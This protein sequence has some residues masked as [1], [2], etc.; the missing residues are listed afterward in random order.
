V[1]VRTHAAGLQ[2]FP[3]RPEG[4]DGFDLDVPGDVSSAAFW[5]AL[6]A[7]LPGTR[8]R[9]E[10]VGL[11]PGRARYLEL[12]RD[13][14]ARLVWRVTGEA[15]GEPFGVVQVESA[16]L[17]D[18]RLAAFDAV[19][20]I[21][22]IP[23]LCAAG[24]IAGCA[25]HVRGAAELRTKETDR[26]AGLVEVLAGFGARAVARADGLS[27]A[28]GTELHAG[29]VRSLGD[30][31]LAMAAAMLALASGGASRIDDVGCVRTSYPE[32]LMDAN[33]LCRVRG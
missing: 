9:V 29:R 26:I 31:R 17:G 30:H 11:N 19:R 14:G 28:A 32:F 7:V 5:I 8:L 10:S 6:G 24:A 3:T 27:V 12:L 13:A 4:W 25:V 2:L 1:E 33:R 18:L 23:A 15:R 22:E 21:D 20:C 16:P